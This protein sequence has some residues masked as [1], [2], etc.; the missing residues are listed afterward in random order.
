MYDPLALDRQRI[1]QER[2][3]RR[4]DL[5]RHASPA[6]AD[7]AETRARGGLHLRTLRRQHRPVA[8]C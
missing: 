6:T 4:S 8:S 3:R 2:L 5:P 1:E 7:R